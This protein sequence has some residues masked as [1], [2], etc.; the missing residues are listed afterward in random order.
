MFNEDWTSD[1]TKKMI[2]LCTHEDKTKRYA[3]QLILL[4]NWDKTGCI[5][6][7]GTDRRIMLN[8]PLQLI[9]REH[10]PNQF[11]K[12]N[13]SYNYH[14]QVQVFALFVKI[15]KLLKIA[16][17]LNNGVTVHSEMCACRHC[18]HKLKLLCDCEHCVLDFIKTYN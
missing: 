2:A 5:T 14:D 11:E 16:I 6:G 13:V 1:E 15:E 17:K 3:Y 18:K 8:E 12:L 10:A 4:N 7:G 9:C